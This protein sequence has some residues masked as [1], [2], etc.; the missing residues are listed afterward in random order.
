MDAA[1]GW[2][3]KEKLQLLKKVKEQESLKL[4]SFGRWFT[5]EEFNLI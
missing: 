5:D 2:Y 1:L 4:K 3:L